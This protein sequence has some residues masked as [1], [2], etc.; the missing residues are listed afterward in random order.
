MDSIDPTSE[1]Q[2]MIERKTL[3]LT[4]SGTLYYSSDDGKSYQDM[5]NHLTKA[6]EKVNSVRKP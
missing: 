6:L 3:L 4:K 2:A 5:S 1:S